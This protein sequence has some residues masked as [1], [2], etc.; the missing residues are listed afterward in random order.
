MIRLKWVEDNNE[1][2]YNNTIF[3]DNKSF[4]IDED[5]VNSQLKYII[6]KNKKIN[7]TKLGR[8]YQYSEENGGFFMLSAFRDNYTK[9]ENI[10]RTKQLEKDLY[11]YKLGYSQTIGRYVYENGEVSDEY[12]F[13]V[14]YYDE[15]SVEEF[16]SIAQKLAKKY[17]QESYLIKIPN[18][19]YI[20]L[21]YTDTGRTENK[22]PFDVNN[23]GQYSSMLAKGNHRNRKWKYDDVVES[24]FGIRVASNNAQRRVMDRNKIY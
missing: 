13:I 18:D 11:D 10:Q 14:P 5:F 1:Y 12:S 24:Y 4:R 16:K 22:K 17:E 8:V 3:S 19:K 2:R 7:E 20:E 23:I 9:E 6:N 21:V 15:Y